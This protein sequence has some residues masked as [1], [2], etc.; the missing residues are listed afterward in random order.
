[1]SSNAYVFDDLTEKYKTIDADL[2]I[3]RMRTEAAELTRKAAAPNAVREAVKKTATSEIEEAAEKIGTSV[4]LVAFIDGSIDAVIEVFNKKIA[5][6]TEKITELE[7]RLEGTLRYED[8]WESGKG[9]HP[10]DLVTHAG[11]GWICKAPTTAKP[12]G[13]PHWK[14]WIKRGDLSK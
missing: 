8:V 10:G 12:G 1:M 6:L 4:N 11:S 13:N 2:R 14:L 9:Y 5:K 3:K 7:N